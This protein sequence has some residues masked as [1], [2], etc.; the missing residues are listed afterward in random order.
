MEMAPRRLATQEQ[1]RT[2]AVLP[3]PPD[4]SVRPYR[5]LETLGVPKL[6]RSRQTHSTRADRPA[7]PQHYIRSSLSC[8]RV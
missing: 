4:T 5:T 3:P 2:V 7:S 6:S 8:V 1:Q